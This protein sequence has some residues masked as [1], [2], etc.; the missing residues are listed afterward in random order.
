M[1]KYQEAYEHLSSRDYK[2]I[3]RENVYDDLEILGELVKKEIPKQAIVAGNQDINNIVRYICPTCGNRFVGKLSDYCYRCGQRFDWNSNKLQEIEKKFNA[4][5]YTKTSRGHVHVYKHENTNYLPDNK[6]TL[7]YPDSIAC[8]WI[9]KDNT[10][11]DILHPAT[12]S[13][14]EVELALAE[15]RAQD[16]NEDE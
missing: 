6:T 13:E 16:W 2:Y 1:N 5:G 4:L 9:S 8:C 11:T 12:M 15:L 10:G 14:Q 3:D 7:I